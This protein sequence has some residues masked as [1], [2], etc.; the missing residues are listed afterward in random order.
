MADIM[1]RELQHNPRTKFV[2]NSYRIGKERAYLGAAKIAGL[3]VWAP[4]EKRKLLDLLGLSE[5][6][7]KVLTN[8]PNV[9]EIH[10]GN[11][12]FNSSNLKKSGYQVIGFRATGW[13]FRKQNQYQA[14]WIKGTKV[15]GIPYSEH[16]SW[17]ELRL[18]VQLLKP[19]KIISTVY[20]KD[21]E[22]IIN[23]FA[24]LMAYKENLEK[25]DVYL[26]RCNVQNTR[27]LY[28]YKFVKNKCEKGIENQDRIIKQNQLNNQIKR[29]EAGQKLVAKSS[30]KQSENIYLNSQYQIENQ[31]Q[32]TYYQDINGLENQN[33]NNYQREDEINQVDNQFPLNNKRRKGIE[34]E[35]YFNLEN[36]NSEEIINQYT[37]KQFQNISQQQQQLQQSTEARQQANQL[38][39]Q[40]KIIQNS[41]QSKNQPENQHIQNSSSLVN[42]P[43]NINQFRN[44][45]LRQNQLENIFKKQS[46]S[47][48]ELREAQV[49]NYEQYVESQAV[50]DLTFEDD[51]S[52]ENIQTE[53]GI[54]S[55]Q[56]SPSLRQNGRRFKSG[57][58]SWRRSIA[59]KKLKTNSSENKKQQGK[60]CLLGQTSILDFVKPLK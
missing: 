52:C 19:K 33:Q 50:I 20:S 8:D 57:S 26:K 28:D 53:K 48:T 23:Q 55:F 32:I 58:R 46:S 5:A 40:F 39:N 17:N 56:R 54:G 31:M 44:C 3:Q 4:P 51:S 14:R 10:V 38:N 24:D 45:Q 12:A 47:I 60:Q 16:S 15:Y 41:F 59:G 43:Q 29:T 2:V 42:Q 35:N 18:C 6:D 13:E 22:K 36:N 7:R 21:P 25:N 37:K 30:E 49:Q 1:I 11:I 9:A 34:F 27:T